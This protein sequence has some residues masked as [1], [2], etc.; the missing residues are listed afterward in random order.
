MAKKGKLGYEH[1]NVNNARFEAD[2]KAINPSSNISL[3]KS[4]TRAY[5]HHLFRLNE[6]LGQNLS[7]L[8][9]LEFYM[10]LMRGLRGKK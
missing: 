5:L 1:L 6:P 10:K 4:H 2:F 7:S 3:L 8:H 9:N